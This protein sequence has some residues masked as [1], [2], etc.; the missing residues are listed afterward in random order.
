MPV[1][2]EE[3]AVVEG[4]FKAMQMGASGEATMMALFTANAV[5]V[6]PFSGE[7]RTHTGAPAI[8]AWFL[9]AVNNM[10][11]QVTLKLDRID[12]DGG[13][14]RADWTCNSPVF[15]KPMK[16]HDLYTLQSGKIARLEMVV[17]DMP[18]MGG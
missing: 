8:R 16:G 11:P 9:D 13:R 14:V 7:V 1:K 18:P 17:T 10:P 2:Q 6:E 4:V 12:Y 15:P 5:I 3:H